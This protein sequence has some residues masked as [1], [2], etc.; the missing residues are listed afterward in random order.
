MFDRRTLAR[1]SDRTATAVAKARWADKRAAEAEGAPLLARMDA[2]G[3]NSLA[4][5]YALEGR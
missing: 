4:E 1:V 5:L 2:A 3:V